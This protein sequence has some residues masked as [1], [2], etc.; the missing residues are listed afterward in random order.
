[1]GGTGGSHAVI[2]PLRD[3]AG[4]SQS[5][6][7]R[8]RS[9]LSVKLKAGYDP[10]MT[11]LLPALGVIFAALVAWLSVRIINRREKWAK[12]TLATAVLLLILYPFSIGPAYLLAMRIRSRPGPDLKWPMTVFETAYAP[13]IRLAGDTNSGEAIAA[14]IEW[15][16]PPPEPAVH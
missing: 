3:G 10:A 2:L 4:E 13:V 16:L 7:R 9:D 12:W 1:M 6:A 14:Y 15:W 11:I 5:Q 8:Y